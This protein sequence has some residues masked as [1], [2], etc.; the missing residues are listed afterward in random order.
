MASEN[1]LEKFELKEPGLFWWND[2]AAPLGTIPHERAVHGQLEI[3]TTGLVSLELDG[4]L[5]Q[6]IIELFAIGQPLEK[7]IAGILNDDNKRVL[8]L[9]VTRNGGT[10]G[11]RSREKFSA[12]YC[13]VGQADVL[14]WEN[15]KNFYAMAADLSTFGE[16]LT[17]SSIEVSKTRS[18]TKAIHKNK[19]DITLKL[20]EGLLDIQ[21]RISPKI[22]YNFKSRQISLA[23]T[24]TLFCRKRFGSLEAIV[25]EFTNL[26]DFF[27]LV[28][29]MEGGFP[30][31]DVFFK[32]SSFPARLYF[33]RLER[34]GEKPNLAKTVLLLA[35]VRP[36][37]SEVVDNWRTARETIGSGIYMYL[38]TR[39]G[40]KS[41]IEN[42]FSIMMMG[43]ES[44][45]RSV[46]KTQV[47]EKLKTKIER[48]ISEVSLTKDKK[49]LSAILRPAPNLKERLIELFSDLPLSISKARLT[50][51]ADECSRNRNDLQHFAST[52]AD[53][54][55]EQFAQRLVELS[56]AL[57]ALYHLKI[58][59]I[60]G[61]HDNSL[62][63][64]FEKGYQ[65][66]SIRMDCWLAGL[67][68]E[69]PRQAVQRQR[70][71]MLSTNP[72]NSES[73]EASAPP[74]T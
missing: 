7:C 21:F 32:S 2:P 52:R 12:T 71:L 10:L 50:N 44:L 69:D 1:S 49:W 4:T 8:L 48:V 28:L 51:F 26:E 45:H 13:L 23:E 68:E 63:W 20:K 60:I 70:P 35:D 15:A 5:S 14:S 66:F 3:G 73:E 67:L 37:L 25:N 11:T 64:I 72:S 41:Y 59:Q 33:S 18:S 39:R 62:L 74:Q 34:S 22:L 55:Y 17:P 47:D 36:Y 58:L 57:S 42:N 43:L 31:P 65:S 16:F 24:V 6:S 40:L 9:K 30:W 19:K 54:T 53:Q 46:G 38:G 56:R 61:I 27:L 29:G